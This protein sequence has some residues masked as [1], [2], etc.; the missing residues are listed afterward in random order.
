MIDMRRFLGTLDGVGITY[1]VISARSAPIVLCS[2][3]GVFIILLL[4]F[5]M[6]T[7]WH[8]LTITTSLANSTH[9]STAIKESTLSVFLGLHSPLI[10]VL[11]E[12]HNN[13]PSFHTDLIIILESILEL[14]CSRSLVII[15]V[16]CN[17][18]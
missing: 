9:L 11:Y 15:F 17:V 12:R 16:D 2:W 3:G 18:V 8:R 6:K 13:W 7:L 1:N 4:F 5:R 10:R 14:V